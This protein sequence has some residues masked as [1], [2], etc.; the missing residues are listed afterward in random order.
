MRL[1]R[2]SY[3]ICPSPEAKET[4]II[5]VVGESWGSETL[6][7]LPRVTQQLSARANSPLLSL[8]DITATNYDVLSVS[9]RLPPYPGELIPATEGHGNFVSA[10]LKVQEWFGMYQHAS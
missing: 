1:I 6:I 7:N 10:H 8:S 5:I 9:T 3:N 4:G 2:T